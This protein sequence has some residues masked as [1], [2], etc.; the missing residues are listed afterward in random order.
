MLCRYESPNLAGCPNGCARPYIAEIGLVG[1][2]PGV[3]NVYLGGGHAGDRLSK[4]WR[5][6]ATEDD[7]VADISRLLRRYAVERASA[8]EKFGDWV[9]RVGIVL[10]TTAGNNFHKGIGD[11][12]APQ[13]AH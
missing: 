2:S 8:T 3:Y 9:I 4:L 7:I 10:E 13:A 12:S 1:R 5:E 6:A 11:A